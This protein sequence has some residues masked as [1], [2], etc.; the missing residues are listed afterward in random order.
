MWAIIP[1]ISPV[2]HLFDQPIVLAYK[3]ETLRLC[4]TNNLPVW[5]INTLWPSNAIWRHRSGSTLA[6]VMALL[7]D[8]TK[9]LPEPMLTYHHWRLI[10]F[11]WRQ[12]HKECSR[13]VSLTWV[14]TLQGQNYNHISQGAMSLNYGTWVSGHLKSGVTWQAKLTTKKIYKPPW[15]FVGRIH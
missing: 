7:P 14:W 11:T 2:N 6:Q 13:N 3:K 12:F 1:L 8:G 5:L 9:P 10:A 4:L 15:P